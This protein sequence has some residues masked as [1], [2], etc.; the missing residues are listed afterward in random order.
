[1][2]IDLGGDPNNCGACGRSCPAVPNTNAS[3]SNGSCSYACKNADYQLACTAPG[4]QPSCSHWD[5]ETP[6]QSD[7]WE[8]RDPADENEQGSTGLL[9][10]STERRLTGSRSLAIGYMK[11]AADG[12]R[13]VDVVVNLCANGQR[14][15][16][17]GKTLRW[18]VYS[19]MPA[20]GHHWVWTDLGGSGDYS[21]GPSNTWNEH[22]FLFPEWSDDVTSIG[23]HFEITEAISWN[24]VI[25]L[26]NVRISTQ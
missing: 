21:S 17:A 3:C 24:G 9:V 23:F 4:G 19:S 11:P 12:K 5:F 25:Y 26:D 15:N 10:S 20:G 22:S 14:V 7:D 18:S 1:M 8:V 2:C 6:N 13:F 16:L